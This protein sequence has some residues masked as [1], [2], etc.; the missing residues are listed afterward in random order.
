MR[1]NGGSVLTILSASGSALDAGAL[2]AGTIVA[3]Y[4]SGST[5]RLLNDLGVQFLRATASGG[6][7]NAITATTLTPV[8]LADGGSLITVTVP[9]ENTGP[10]DHVINGVAALSVVGVD[11]LPLAAGDLTPGMLIS[12]YKSGGSFRLLSDPSSLRNKVAAEAAQAG[13]EVA[14]DRSADEADRSEAAR[15]IAA[16][17]AS[18]AVSQGNVPIYATTA[19]LSALAVPEGVGAIRTN[20][21]SAAGNGGAALLKRVPA[22]PEGPGKWPSADGA[23]WENAETVADALAFYEPTD[24]GIQSAINRAIDFAAA[25]GSSGAGGKVVVPNRGGEY[26]LTGP[27]VLK[28]KVILEGVGNP[29]IKL[30]AGVKTDL[31]QTE[32]FYD[33]AG[34]GNSSNDTPNGFAILN[35]ILDGNHQNQ[36]P[37]DPDACN[38]L[39]LYGYK[40][41]VRD[42]LVTNVKGNGI[43][44]EW[45]PWGDPPGG[46]EATFQD[47]KIDTAGRHGFRM[48]GPHDS[49]IDHMIVTD[50]SQEADDTYDAIC[51]GDLGNGRFFNIHSWHRAEVENRVRFGFSGWGCEITTSHLEG[52]RRQL[53]LRGECQVDN[54]LIYAGFGNDSQIAIDGVGNRLRGKF[55]SIPAFP[56][57]KVIEFGRNVAAAASFVELGIS[58]QPGEAAGAPVIFTAESGGNYVDIQSLNADADA[59]Y[60]GTPLWAT[61]LKISQSWPI[62]YY[63]HLKPHTGLTVQYNGWPAKAR[64]GNVAGSAAISWNG[65]YGNPGQLLAQ[66]SAALDSLGIVMSGGS[67]KFFGDGP[68]STS[69]TLSGQLGS[70]G[71]WYFHDNVKITPLAVGFFGA[72]PHAKPTVSGSISGGTALKSFLDVHGAV[73][74]HRRRDRSMTVEELRKIREQYPTDRFDLVFDESGSLIAV[75]AKRAPDRGVALNKAPLSKFV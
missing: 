63:V 32:D 53:W 13:S 22:S 6:T 60:A 4:K 23:W 28:S 31:I 10:A 21:S 34:T 75:A 43:R 26:A 24:S 2:K 71:T 56:R 69:A 64:F 35:L 8:P 59:M 11:G 15:D 46:M 66:D 49:H 17:Y 27:I 30:A 38:G 47:V 42:V 41:L 45:G 68:G 7:A 54:S 74:P 37:S 14:A 36:A 72:V 16:G 39:A 12:G 51:A 55:F 18:D 58:L 3:G 48:D 57:P 25:R 5:F 40:F 29:T 70:N 61:E 44:S 73:G 19:G 33:L 1:F 50:A 62:P 67:I 65:D 9:S 52:G 20:G